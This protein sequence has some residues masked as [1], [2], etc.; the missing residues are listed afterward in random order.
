MEHNN[1]Q[2]ADIGSNACNQQTEIDRSAFDQLIVKEKK[3]MYIKI[4]EFDEHVVKAMVQFLY[5]DFVNNETLR[6]FGRELL[7]AA[8]MYDIVCLKMI[9]EQYLTKHELTLENCGELL[10]L[11]DACNC[12]RFHDYILKYVLKTKRLFHS[13]KHNAEL[14]NFAGHLQSRPYLF[15]NVLRKLTET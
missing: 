13:K 2:S 6:K 14:S 15:R 11:A 7:R 5:T 8:D 12:E 3:M 10:V 1:I 4:D 9:V